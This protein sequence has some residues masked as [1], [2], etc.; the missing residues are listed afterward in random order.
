MQRATA[1]IERFAA[2]AVVSARNSAQV[3]SE[4]SSASRRERKAAKPDR[5]SE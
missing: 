4:Q 2:T 1:A 5:V 3:G